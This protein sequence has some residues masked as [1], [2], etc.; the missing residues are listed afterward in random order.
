MCSIQSPSTQLIVMNP[1]CIGDVALC[2]MM[3]FPK[4]HSKGL[5]CAHCRFQL[6][7]MR[8]CG[9]EMAADTSKGAP[10]SV[11]CSAG[12]R[13]QWVH[14]ACMPLLANTTF[15]HQPNSETVSARDDHVCAQAEAG[16]VR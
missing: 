11:R 9:R 5:A 14:P 3:G 1:I 8:L 15:G 2:T 13:G 16:Q 6:Q 10:S 7:G 12:R 4:R